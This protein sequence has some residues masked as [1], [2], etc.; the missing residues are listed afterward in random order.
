M[1]QGFNPFDQSNSNVVNIDIFHQNYFLLFFYSSYSESLEVRLYHYLSWLSC[2]KIQKPEKILFHTDC[3]PEG[4]YW[5]KF[6]EQAGDDLI[7]VKRSQ[8][9][10][11]W[12]Q[13]MISS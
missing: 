2:L 13:E 7:I 4:N 1:L 12:E 6:K 10:H 8:P 11:I 9:T 5:E 3:Q